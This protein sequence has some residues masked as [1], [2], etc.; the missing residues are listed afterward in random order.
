[1]LEQ[2]GQAP[3]ILFLYG[4]GVWCGGWIRAACP[5]SWVWIPL[6]LGEVLLPFH[7]PDLGLL[8]PKAGP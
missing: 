2:R 7:A 5:E 4:E 1:M 3:L 6:M 8:A